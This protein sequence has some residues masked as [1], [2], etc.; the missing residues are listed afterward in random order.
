MGGGSGR[1]PM[2][3]HFEAFHDTGLVEPIVVSIPLGENRAMYSHKCLMPM[4][5][6][7]VIGGEEVVFSKKESFAIIDDHKG[8]YP[9]MMHYD[10]LTA[11]GYDTEGRLSGFNLTDNQSAD[12][13]KYNENCLWV[14]G[15]LFL[16][17]PVK[18]DRPQ[19]VDGEWRV[20]DL[21]GMV[22][23]SFRPVSMGKIDMNLL[24]VKVSYF[25]PFGVCGGRIRDSLGREHSFDGYFGMGEKKF[26]RG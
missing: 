22:D 7:L 1:P 9:Y 12:P 11:A 26:V 16:L 13:E 8:F 20:R 10:W 25:G 21:Y 15:R 24:A 17:P 6:S 3:G 14:D 5:G 23:L 2:E 18:F 19:G 4:Q